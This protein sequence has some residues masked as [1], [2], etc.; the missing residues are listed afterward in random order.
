[1]LGRHRINTSA[2]L[3]SSISN[4]AFAVEERVVW[5]GVDVLRGVV[6]VAKWPF[7]RA[8]WA[9]E[10]GLVW[11]LEERTGDWSGPLRS[12]GVAIVAL[13]AVGAGVLGLLWASG[14]GGSATPQTQSASALPGTPA[15]VRASKDR[16]ALSAPVLHGVAPDF[17]HVGNGTSTAAGT[18]VTK[19]GSEAAG[20]AAAGT[21]ET[22]TP[23]PTS[24]T[25]SSSST[26]A[27]VTPAGPA[28]TKVAHRFSGAFVLYETGQN[29]QAV[30]TAFAATATP[31]LTREL[32]RRPPRLPANVKV[33]K[34]KVLNIVP[35]PTHGGTYTLSVSLLRVGV[36]TELRLEM[37]RNVKSGEWQVARVL[38]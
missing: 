3:R 23:A 21:A 25:A 30:R 13:L 28:A 11:P 34:A 31:Q 12:A 27:K 20:S 29:N 8:I 2:P 32:L 10:R 18:T 19:A 37:K 38:G 24:S 7:E 26:T 22:S 1:M 35:G 14:S 33:P 17:K 36:T 4:A 15:T 9:I 16:A 5:G 6:E